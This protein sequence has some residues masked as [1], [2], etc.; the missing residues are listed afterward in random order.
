MLKQYKLLVFIAMLFL[1]SSCYYDSEES[2]FPSLAAC[3]SAQ[4][5]FKTDI[6]PLIDAN[7]NGCHN[8]QAPI[9]KTYDNIK[10]NASTMY[11]DIVSGKMPQ[12]GTPLDDCSKKQFKKWMDYGMPQN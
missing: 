3:D 7:C 10:S 6:L 8:N 1:V 5:S 12:G 11:N 2:L 4:Y 9:L